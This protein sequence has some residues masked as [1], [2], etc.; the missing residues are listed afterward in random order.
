MTGPWLALGA[1][2]VAALLVAEWRDD[3]RLLWVA[4]PL[5][6][7]AFVAFALAGGAL[8]TPYGRS[9][10]VA[11]VLSWLGDVLLIPRDARAFKAGV[12]AFGLGHVAFVAA[13]LLYGSRTAVALPLLA[14]LAIVAW[15]VRRHLRPTVPA[16]LRPAVDGY[17]VVI[18]A[19]LATAVGTLAP[20]IAGGALAFYL[21]DLSVARDR[22]VRPSFVNRAWGL[23]L[24]YGAQF[25]LA[26]TV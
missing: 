7:T 3:R 25:V 6:S 16:T 10:L 20:W 24:Y 9:I 21:S 17:M 2:S 22:F 15:L 23:P 5:S 12:L 8:E 4:K 18:T 1:V 14:P 13:F 11:L 26:A 19:M